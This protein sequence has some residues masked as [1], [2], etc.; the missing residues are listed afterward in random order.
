MAILIMVIKIFFLDL[1]LMCY[2]VCGSKS[3]LIFL[4]VSC[5][6]NLGVPFVSNN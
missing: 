5:V 6:R 2:N 1:P 3:M 4:H